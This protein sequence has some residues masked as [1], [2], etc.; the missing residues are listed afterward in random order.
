VGNLITD[1]ETV[2]GETYATGIAIRWRA[3]RKLAREVTFNIFTAKR[4]FCRHEIRIYG[5]Q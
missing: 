2:L 4:V 5:V 1:W 3:V